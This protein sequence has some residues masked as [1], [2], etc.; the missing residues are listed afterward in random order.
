MRDLESTVHSALECPKHLGTGAGPGQTHVQE[1]AEGTGLALLT[2]HHEVVSVWLCLPLV[3][4]VQVEL[5]QHLC[6][7]GR[8]TEL[9]KGVRNSGLLAQLILFRVI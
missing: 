1:A 7:E 4:A 2:L 8:I 6:S 5:L 3:D 9:I